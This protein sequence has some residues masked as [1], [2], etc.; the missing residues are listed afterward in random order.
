[1]WTLLIL[2][3]IVN[4]ILIVK[5]REK[6]KEGKYKPVVFDNEPDIHTFPMV[7]LGVLQII[8]LI[9]IMITYLP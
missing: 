9:I 5:F 1:M 7:L 2:S 6:V 4:T 3:L 8:A